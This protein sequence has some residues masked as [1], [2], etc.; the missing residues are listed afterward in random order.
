LGECWADETVGNWASGL[1]DK[2][3]IWSVRLRA[4]LWEP[5]MDV[6]QTDSSLVEPTVH[7]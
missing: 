6:E 7:H 2:K 4:D 3:G 5:P 1:A